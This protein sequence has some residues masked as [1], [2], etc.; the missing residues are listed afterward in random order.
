MVY[1]T[2]QKN[3]GIDEDYKRTIAIQKCGGKPYELALRF[4]GCCLHCGACFASGYSW[5]EKFKS[6]RRVKGYTEPYAVIKDFSDIPYP[7]NYNNYNWLRILGGEPL[8]NDEY[9]EF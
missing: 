6:N 2:L 4:A 8:L 3:Y 5:P 9:I 7:R 1:L